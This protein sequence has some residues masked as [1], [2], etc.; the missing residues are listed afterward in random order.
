[1]TM[2]WK[3]IL[4]SH[5]KTILGWN[6]SRFPNAY[7]SNLYISNFYNSQIYRQKKQKSQNVLFW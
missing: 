4:L 6:V 1:M 3:K 7:Y 5:M 2:S